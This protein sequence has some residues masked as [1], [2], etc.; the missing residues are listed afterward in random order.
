MNV[1]KENIY[2]FIETLR[3]NDYNGTQIYQIL[4]Q[5]WP[6]ECISV[7]RIRKIMKEFED[8]QRDSFQRMGNSGRKKSEHRLE[9]VDNVRNIIEQDSCITVREISQQLDISHT[10]VHN[11]MCED[12][13]LIWH[14]TKWVP[15]TLTERNRASRVA[16]CEELRVIYAS[17][18]TRSN[19]VTIDEKFFYCR[20]LAPSNKIGNWLNETTAQGDDPIRHTARRSTMEKKFMAI[21]AVSQKGEHYFEMLDLNESVNAERYT[22]FL[23]HMEA[24]FK[25]LRRPIMPENMRL[26]HDNARPHTALQTQAHLENLN[27]RLIR[28]PAYSPDLNLCDRYIFPRLEASRHKTNFN[29][30]DDIQD[31]LNQKLSE[32]TA[33]RMNNALNDLQEHLEKV[34]E[35]GGKY[36]T[37]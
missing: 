7:Q 9:N 5:S 18:L 12:L 17:R 36:V 32:F 11:I 23:T 19:L 29:S 13:E 27:I 20:S 31:F 16:I 15:H 37:V 34:I 33:A 26:Q 6:G 22:Q 4:H 30:R 8:G 21:I 14:H 25:N 35:V 24:H 10:M 3:R 28:Q 1:T 2:F